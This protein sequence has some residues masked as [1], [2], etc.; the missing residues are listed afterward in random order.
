MAGNHDP[1][2]NIRAWLWLLAVPFL[3]LWVPLY[4]SVEPTLF[5]FP[6]F[7]W[8]QLAWIFVSMIITAVVYY[9]TEP[10]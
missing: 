1:D 5:G 10:R 4:N 7:Y 9:S 8:F 6:F 3:V 2:G